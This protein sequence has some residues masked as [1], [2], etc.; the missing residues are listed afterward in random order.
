MVVS[1]IYTSDK[2]L[3][4]QNSQLISFMTTIKSPEKEK[5][6]VLYREL[7]IMQSPIH[8]SRKQILKTEQLNQ[9]S[10]DKEKT[11]SFSPSK[12]HQARNLPKI[13]LILGAVLFPGC[14]LLRADVVKVFG[15]QVWSIT[16]VPGNKTITEQCK[17]FG[18]S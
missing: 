3:F 18:V 4:D 15:T 9:I 8:S 13:S 16:K 10:K 2:F 6:S 14:Q 1:Q 7:S 12:I 17:L 11:V 5:L